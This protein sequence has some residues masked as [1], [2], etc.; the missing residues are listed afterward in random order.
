MECISMRNHFEIA[1]ELVMMQVGELRLCSDRAATSQQWRRAS[2]EIQQ[3]LCCSREAIR[4][5]GDSVSIAMRFLSDFKAIDQRFRTASEVIPTI[6]NAITPDFTA[7]VLR[8]RSDFKVI[9]RRFRS[10]SP[11]I[12]IR[13][14]I[15]QRLCSDC[16]SIAQ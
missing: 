11:A 16:A 4:S 2:V 5:R 1:T 10:N 9:A 14:P 8:I 7:N 15:P 6:R 13:A 12:A 3:R